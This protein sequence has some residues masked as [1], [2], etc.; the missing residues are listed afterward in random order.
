MRNDI[1]Q[2]LDWQGNAEL[3]ALPAVSAPEF[4]NGMRHF[5]VGV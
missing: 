4:R 5:A 3:A 1:N 2:R